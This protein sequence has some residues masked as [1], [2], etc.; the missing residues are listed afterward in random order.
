MFGAER[1]TILTREDVFIK[2]LNR[3]ILLFRIL[4]IINIAS[5]IAQLF[6]MK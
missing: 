1:M 6:L 4:I 5:S 2:K 3:N